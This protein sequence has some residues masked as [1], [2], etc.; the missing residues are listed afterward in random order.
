MVQM[1]HAAATAGRGMLWPMTTAP[2]L[3][4]PASDP[5]A[6]SAVLL[7]VHRAG[8]ELP[9]ARFQDEALALVRR[10]I[11][12]DSAWWGNAAAEPMEI[13]RLHLHN[14]ADTI[15]QDY[16]P[17]IGEDFFRAQLM[18]H[19]GTTVNMAD[20]I[21]RA[22]FVRTPMYQAVGR[23]YHIEWSLG[24]LLVEAV[25]SLQ[26]FLT[27]WRHDPQRPFNEV[28]R[29]CK[30]LLMPH[31]ADA[32]RAARRREMLDGTRP[33]H[34][35]W[36]VLDERGYLREASPGFVH[37][38]RGTWPQWQ[39]SLL[40]AALREALAQPGTPRVGDALCHVLP[41]GA[42]RYLH[43]QPVQRT[44]LLSARQRSIARRFAAGETHSAIAAS[45]GLSPATVRNHLAACY[46]KLSVNN[47]AELVLRMA[48]SAARPPA[49]GDA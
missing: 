10:L 36:A 4:T 25:S 5:R 14:C 27:V 1:H 35:R 24:T 45:L 2:A 8:Q 12:F 39:G 48:A 23:P 30:E 34:S 15:L 21:S 47:K 43:V 26:E 29:Q 44:D 28:E 22:D 18:A 20:L 31:L 16:A 19:P 17:F 40:P 42:F 33:P 9:L 3:A 41:K 32:H 49:A 13:H 38:V 6:I 37:W 7:D 11:P 46:R